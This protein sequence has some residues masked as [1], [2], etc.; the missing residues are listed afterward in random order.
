MLLAITTLRSELFNFK[1][2]R[3]KDDSTLQAMPLSCDV[4]AKP[5]LD[6]VDTNIGNSHLSILINILETA[7]E[8]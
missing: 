2:H 6:N 7:P 1:P 5:I 3:S 4:S 8:N